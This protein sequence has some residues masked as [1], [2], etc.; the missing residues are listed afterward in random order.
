MKFERIQRFGALFRHSV[1]PVIVIAAL[2][3]GF[4]IPEA[5][6]AAVCTGLTSG[7]ADNAAT[8]YATASVTPTA[9]R[10]VLV[11]VH[12]ANQNE[13]PGT[14]TLS[15]NGLTYVQ[16]ATVLF[17]TIAAPD[18]RL[19]LFRAMGAA[20]SAGAITISFTANQDGANWSV[21]ECSGTDTGG[22]NGSAAVVQSAT[23]R[24]NSA[25]S[26][27]VTLA[28]FGSTD[29]ATYG[30]F[31]I[32]AT[33]ALVQGTGFTEIHEVQSSDT[34]ARSTMTEWRNDNDTSVDGSWASL[35]TA[36]GIAIEI[37]AAAA[38]TIIKV[39]LRGNVRLTGR[40]VRLR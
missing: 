23:N 4:D 30:A 7:L 5:R 16:V 20:P 3:L 18:G 2:V 11:A 21:V 14:P 25:S 35:N 8:S 24:T 15:G 31:A 12:S 13:T 6:A 19:T 29:N 28:A 39:R 38:A 34:P 36:A 1:L 37:K 17:D 22:T 26:L 10:L 27:T 40:L 32:G 33:Q 9:N